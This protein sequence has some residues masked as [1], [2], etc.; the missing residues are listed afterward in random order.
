MPTGRVE[1]YEMSCTG[2]HLQ[3]DAALDHGFH[4]ITTSFG[5]KNV[6]ASKTRVLKKQQKG[7]MRESLPH[8]LLFFRA[9]HKN[10][11]LHFD[12]SFD[13]CRQGG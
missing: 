9:R 2:K 3:D 8:H 6:N 10:V 7:K 5:G 1:G 12:V 4:S 11:I 13:F